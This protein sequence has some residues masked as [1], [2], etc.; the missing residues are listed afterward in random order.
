MEMK[1]LKGIIEGHTVSEL[2][3]F[4]FKE[5]SNYHFTK[6]YKGME[7]AASKI[8]SFDYEEK[9]EEKKLTLGSFA[10]GVPDFKVGVLAEKINELSAKDK[11][12]EKAA[13]MLEKEL[14][15]WENLKCDVT[16]IVNELDRKVKAIFRLQD[17]GEIHC[18]HEAICHPDDDFVLEIGKLVAVYKASYNNWYE[19]LEDAKLI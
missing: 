14:R 9:K 16:F 3:E 1:D 13:E 12:R 6:L 18:V 4:M 2:A 19:R 7:Q 17:T 10:I 8:D 11:K 5:L 15:D